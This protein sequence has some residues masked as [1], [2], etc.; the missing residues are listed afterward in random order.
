MVFY[1]VIDVS[2]PASGLNGMNDAV[3]GSGTKIVLVF[4]P[5]HKRSSMVKLAVHRFESYQA[6]TGS[7]GHRVT[8]DKLPL[9]KFFEK[10]TRGVS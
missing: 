6:E 5:R 8:P 2:K 4:V 7:S 1:P 3:S 10:T 9:S